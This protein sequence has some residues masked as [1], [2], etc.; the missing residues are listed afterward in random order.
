MSTV[1]QTTMQMALE[2]YLP[3][4]DV[5]DMMVIGQGQD[6][7][8]LQRIAQLATDQSL[9]CRSRP[10][11]LSTQCQACNHNDERLASHNAVSVSL[12]YCAQSLSM[13]NVS[14]LGKQMDDEKVSCRL[15]LLDLN[16]NFKS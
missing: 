11:T 13:Y 7:L 8:I 10:L 4:R 12:Q 5:F 9:H 15:S 6:V 14:F 2:A 3:V 16:L 1:H